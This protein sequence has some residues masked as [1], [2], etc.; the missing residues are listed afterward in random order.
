MYAN[1]YVCLYIYKKYINMYFNISTY[2]AHTHICMFISYITIQ[3]I[4]TKYILVYILYIHIHICIFMHVY[5]IQICIFKCIIYISRTASWNKVAKEMN[6]QFYRRKVGIVKICM[7]RCL[8]TRIRELQN[9][10]KRDTFYM[11]GWNKKSI[12][13][14]DL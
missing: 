3:M 8:T 2:S 14:K 12:N 7:P 5:I 6:E 11:S 13:S 1:R 9:E 4:Y 10:I